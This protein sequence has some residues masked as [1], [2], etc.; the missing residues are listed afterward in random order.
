MRPKEKNDGQF[1]LKKTNLSQNHSVA[2]EQVDGMSHLPGLRL[3][4]H[5]QR[6]PIEGREVGGTR[7]QALGG[8][9]FAQRLN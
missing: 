5:L 4:H 6:V 2:L 1:K 9:N 3:R 8:E 7:S